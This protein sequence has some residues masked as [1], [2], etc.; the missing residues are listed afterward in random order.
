MTR[1]VDVGKIKSRINGFKKT[2]NFGMKCLFKHNPFK[3]IA[4][5]FILMMII[6]AVAIRIVE[7]DSS[8]FFQK[9]L[10]I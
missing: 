7:F 4:F 9:V 5:L 8:M 6:F 2:M 3:L 10:R 1:P